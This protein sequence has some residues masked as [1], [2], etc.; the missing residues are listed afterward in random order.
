VQTGTE[1]R[2]YDPQRKPPNW[3]DCMR[4]TDCAVFLKDRR[5]S[6]SLDSNGR[7][8]YNAADVTCIIFECLEAARQFCKIKVEALPQVRCEI[9]DAEGMAHPPL[10]VIVHSNHESEEEF[11]VPSSR[12]RQA[13]VI[14]LLVMSAVLFWIGRRWSEN[15]MW[16]LAA[17][18]IVVALRLLYWDSGLKHR[19]GER[20]ARLEA[21]L[22]MERSRYLN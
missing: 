18:C 4:A 7:P 14:G 22:K 10:L 3:I 21:H 20:R 11:S 6:A 13:A 15:L 9:Y 16:I 8:Y 12:R 1:I 2:L 17:N 5:T 19:E